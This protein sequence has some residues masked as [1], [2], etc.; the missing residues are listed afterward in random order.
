M[1]I[2]PTTSNARRKYLMR[3]VSSMFFSFRLGYGMKL[4]V[5]FRQMVPRPRTAYQGFTIF[6][7]R[8]A[9]SMLQT[10]PRSWSR[11]TFA[12]GL[13]GFCPVGRPLG[14]YPLGWFVGLLEKCP[15]WPWRLL[16]TALTTINLAERIS[17]DL[18]SGV[19]QALGLRRPLRPPGRPFNNLRWVFDRAS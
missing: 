2:R 7:F 6:G 16:T 8:L 17:R 14:S 9:G 10:K 19:G 1:K 15:C 12:S 18:G 5:R 3:P 4:R 13:A 11:L